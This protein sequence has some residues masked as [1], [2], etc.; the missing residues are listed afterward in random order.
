VNGVAEA[1]NPSAPYNVGSNGKL[2][3][4]SAVQDTLELHYGKR[5]GRGIAWRAG[6]TAYQILKDRYRISHLNE[7][8]L[9]RFFPLQSRLQTGLENLV[10][11][12]IEFDGMQVK[13]LTSAEGWMWRSEDCHVCQG[14]SSD[15]SCCHF[16]VG[17]LQACLD[18]I[19]GGR[20]FDVVETSCKA[21]GDSACDFRIIRQPVD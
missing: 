17:L 5:G 1:I 4:A 2:I 7:D 13:L 15:D 16:T 20:A 12:V 14:R 3:K 6:R 19:S 10:K 8:S 9:F 18:W 11:A 21:A